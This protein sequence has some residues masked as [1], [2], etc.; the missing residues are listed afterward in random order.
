M[1][2][3][4]PSPRDP[5]TKTQFG[6]TTQ[7]FESNRECAAFAWS[8]EQSGFAVHDRFRNASQPSGHDRTRGSHRFENH[9][10]ENITRSRGIHHAGESKN[11]ARAQ[12]FEDLILRQ[13]TGQ[14]NNIVELQCSDLGLQSFAQRT[15]AND[16][17]GAVHAAAAKFPRRPQSDARNL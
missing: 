10:G 15:I 1:L 17:A 3:N 8:D 16:L 2:L 11:I 13:S 9:R 4:S 14:R 6:V 7:F 5:K 12:F